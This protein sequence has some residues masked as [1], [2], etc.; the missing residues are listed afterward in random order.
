M[1][2]VMLCDLYDERLQYQDNLFAKYYVKHGHQV[3]VIASTFENAFD[4]EAARYDRRAPAREYRDGDA[5]IVKLPY[6]INVMNRLRKFGGVRNILV[7]EKPDL[8]FSHDIHLNLPDAVWYRRS[9][10]KCRIIMD[11]HADFSNSGRTWLSLLLMHRLTRKRMLDACRPH[12]DKIYPIVPAG[13]DFLHE[14]YDI[15][16]SEM[17]LLPLGAD[18]DL[19]NETRAGGSGSR[20]REQMGIPDG[21]LV[22][23]TGGKLAPAKRTH[24]LIDAVTEVDDPNLHVLIVGDVGV[25]DEDYKATLLAR[26]SANARVHMVG[27]VDG[28]DVY[29]YM[30]ACDFAVFPASQSV[31]WQQALSMGLPLIVGRVG[32]ADPS[33]MNVY[34]NMMILDEADITAPAIA[35][36]IREI[37]ADRTL[38]KVRQLAALRVA[39]E[40]LNQHRLVEETLVGGASRNA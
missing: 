37:I 39:D 17:T 24:L 7:R 14:V 26:A 18:T 38:L 35:R 2:I 30:D 22:I 11:Y 4:Y 40:L 21:A 13:A 6:S 27:W 23:F 31:L 20:L 16:Y 34:D 25:A 29:R 12:I 8:I 33:Y 5:K 3:T 28:A 9:Y 19:A 15:P 36:K 10:P 1:K 32:V